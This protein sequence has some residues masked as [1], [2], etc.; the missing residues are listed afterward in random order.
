MCIVKLLFEKIRSCC[1][2]FPSFLFIYLFFFQTNNF[3]P[4]KY[5]I[6]NRLVLRESSEK[7][8]KNTLNRLKVFY[9]INLK[10]PH[11]K[12]HRSSKVLK[13]EVYKKNPSKNLLE[14]AQS[15]L[16]GL[17]KMFSYKHH[18]YGFDS[19]SINVELA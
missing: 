3:S 18:E 17:S 1:P 8:Y 14:L 5:Q 15:Q 10:T 2:L 19:T 4:L 13:S 6:L 12:V 11:L 16:K 9:K 7:F